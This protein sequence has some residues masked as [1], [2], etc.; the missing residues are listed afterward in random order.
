MSLGPEIE[1]P[2]KL[3]AWRAWCYVTSSYTRNVT[4][5]NMSVQITGISFHEGTKKLT[6]GLKVDDELKLSV[7]VPYL[8]GDMD[9]WTIGQI[10]QAAIASAGSKIPSKNS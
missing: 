6:V 4:E 2:A 9:S 10:R 5:I 1:K 8:A 3:V 7:L